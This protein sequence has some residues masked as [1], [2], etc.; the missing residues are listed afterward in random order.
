MT[1]LI[2]P[3]PFTREV[4]RLLD[5]VFDTQAGPQRWA[6]PMDLTESEDHYLLRA[7][8]PGMSEDEVSIEVDNGVLTVAGERR[9]EHAE[10]EKG[11]HRIERSFGRFQR[12]L[13]LPDGVDAEALTAEFDRG[14]LSV[15]IP[16]PQRV[17]P[18]RIAIGK[19]GSNG[20]P[21]AVEGASDD[22]EGTAEE[23]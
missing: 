22:V 10:R 7:D 16:K 18:H 1:L 12:Q 2:R 14:V 21:A 15:R 13:T 19:A 6:P 9:A 3:E 4:D 11:W 8:L 20:G 17:R 23:K 5:R